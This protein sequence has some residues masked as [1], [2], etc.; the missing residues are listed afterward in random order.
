MQKL[1]IATKE[2]FGYHIDSY[3]YAYYLQNKIQ[4]SYICLD[5][6]AIKID[7]KNVNTIYVSKKGSKVIRYLRFLK[8]INREIRIEDY[9]VVFIVYFFGCS[10]LRIL[11]PTKNFNL[12]IRTASVEKNLLI[13]FFSDLILKFETLFFRNISIIGE[14]LKRVLKLNNAHILPLGGECFTSKSHSNSGFHLIYVGSLSNRNILDFIKG[15]HL[16]LKDM[17]DQIDKTMIS[18]TVVGD[19]PGNELVEINIYIQK[20]QLESYI[21]TTGYIANDQ[22]NCIF[23]KCNFGVSFI[24]LTEYFQNQPPTKTF[25]YLLSGLPVI[26]TATIENSKIINI[27]NGV[28]IQDKVESIRSGLHELFT[29]RLLFDSESIK[30]ALEHFLWKNIVLNNLKPYLEL[31]SNKKSS[32]NFGQ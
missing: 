30:K 3:K 28:L 21:K 16:F 20:N 17:T 19:S 26:A 24:P 6:G 1:L 7:P 11:N 27:S 29:N 9:D 8:T 25:E 14:N 10:I 13:N 15:F 22:L 4:I 2:Q 32:K 5:Q 31:L 18:L 23:E 12:D